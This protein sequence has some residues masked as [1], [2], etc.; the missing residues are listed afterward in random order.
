MSQTTTTDSLSLLAAVSKLSN[1]PDAIPPR[2]H[3]AGRIS[4]APLAP[5][6]KLHLVTALPR[7]LRGVVAR[8]EKP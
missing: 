7:K 3:P 5:V 4:R 2:G 1:N 6:L 8:V